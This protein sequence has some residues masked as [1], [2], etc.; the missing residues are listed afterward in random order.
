VEQTSEQEPVVEVQTPI[1]EMEEKPK[2]EPEVVVEER[3]EEPKQPTIVEK[4]GRW[5]NNLTKDVTE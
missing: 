2:V 1:V 4:W 3:K 5:L